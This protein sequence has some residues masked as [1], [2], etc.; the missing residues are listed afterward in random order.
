LKTS[1]D[2]FANPNSKSAGWLREAGFRSLADVQA[3][4][5][6]E[7]YR[8][9]RALHPRD[10]SLNLLWALEAALLGIRWDQLPTEIKAELLDQL[11]HLDEL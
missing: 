10:V 2:L 3:V 7:A 9:T 4:G 8:R 1:G 5:S 6:V 11:A